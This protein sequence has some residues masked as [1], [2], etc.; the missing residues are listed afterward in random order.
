MPAPTKQPE[1]LTLA[2]IK[3]QL[4]DY[5]SLKAEN[6]ELKRRLASIQKLAN[7]GGK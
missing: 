6:R 7:S 2:E 4:E 5:A 3:A 1:N